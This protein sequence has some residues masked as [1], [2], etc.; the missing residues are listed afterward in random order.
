MDQNGRAQLVE[1]SSLPEPRLRRAGGV[2][3]LPF[4]SL[5]L[6]ERVPTRLR[7]GVRRTGV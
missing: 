5:L 6:E 1:S 4:P 2:G 7:A 3:A